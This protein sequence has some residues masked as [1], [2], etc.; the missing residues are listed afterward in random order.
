MTLSLPL[1]VIGFATAA[2]FWMEFEALKTER[3]GLIYVGI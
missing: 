2:A 1:F 3:L